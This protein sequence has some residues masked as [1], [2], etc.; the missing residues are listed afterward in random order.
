M[1]A[2]GLNGVGDV[3][4]ILVDHGDERHAM[5]CSQVAKDLLEGFDVVGAIIRREGDAG[6]QDFDMGFFQRS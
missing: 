1:N 5:A 3:D 2:V 6:E 4:Q